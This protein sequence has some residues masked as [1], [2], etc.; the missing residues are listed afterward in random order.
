MIL[1]CSNFKTKF[2]FCYKFVDSW[3]LHFMESWHLF[4]IAVFFKQKSDDS[5]PQLLSL[6]CT[7]IVIIF[8]ESAPR[9][10]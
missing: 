7:V 1:N 8:I 5:E 4:N 9:P 3:D 2:T 6:I 10:T